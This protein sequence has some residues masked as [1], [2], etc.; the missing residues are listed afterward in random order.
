M[1]KRGCK[2]AAIEE[3]KP[4]WIIWAACPTSSPVRSCHASGIYV[5]DSIQD[6]T[7]CAADEELEVDRVGGCSRLR[8]RKAFGSSRTGAPPPSQA[9]LAAS[10]ALGAGRSY[11]AMLLPADPACAHPSSAHSGGCITL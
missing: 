3:V 6:K 8:R 4:L 11:T 9:A 7:A 1:V 5:L 10:E 2:C